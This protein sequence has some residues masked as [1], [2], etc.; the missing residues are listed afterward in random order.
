MNWPGGLPDSKEVDRWISI[1]RRQGSFT[2]QSSAST[3]EFLTKCLAEGKVNYVDVTGMTALHRL[4][5][6]GDG[7]IVQEFLEAGAD[8]E[9]LNADGK[10]ALDV[11]RAVGNSQAEQQISVVVQKAKS[12]RYF[13]TL[14]HLGRVP[15]FAR[16][17][18]AELPELAKAFDWRVYQPGQVVIK[19]GDIGSEFF[20]IADGIAIVEIDGQK[21]NELEKNDY[22]G[23]MALLKGDPRNATITASPGKSLS[24][25]VLS[26][27]SFE[28]L[29][30][31][32]KLTFK[33]RQAVVAVS[34][35]V[36][37]QSQEIPPKTA[38]NLD[39]LLAA[40]KANKAFSEMLSNVSKEEL[41]HIAEKAMP[42]ALP[43]NY[44]IMVEGDVKAD[45]FYIL[46][47]GS[48]KIQI[49]AQ[50]IEAKIFPGGSFGELALMYRAPR[51]ATITT[52]EN[53]V[54]WA[55]SRAQLREVLDKTLRKKIAE[56]KNTLGHVALLQSLSEKEMETVANAV[57]QKEFVEGACIFEQGEEGDAL[58]ILYNGTVSVEKDGAEVA[59][60]TGDSKLGQYQFFGEKALLEDEARAASIKCVSAAVTCLV[61][62]RDSFQKMAAMKEL[63]RPA[64]DEFEY[65]REKLIPL[66]ELGKGAFGLVT[67]QKERETGVKFALK[68]LSKGFVI[69]QHQEASVANEKQIM[70]MTDSPF[71]VRLA[72]TFNTQEHVEFL[73]EAAMGGELYTVYQRNDFY[74][75]EAMARFF[76]A[77]AGAGLSHLHEHNIIY[78][79]LK[80]ENLLLDYRGYGK[81]AD[82]GLAKFVLGPSYTL[83]GTP[84]YF[85]PEICD[86]KGYTKAVDWWGV[87][88]LAFELMTGD[89]P[90][91]ADDPMQLLAEARGGLKQKQFK[92]SIGPWTTFVKAMLSEDASKRL[93]MRNG[94]FQN[95]EAH[96]WFRAG[97]QLDAWNWELFY[98]Q[99]AEPPYKPPKQDENNLSNF[100]PGADDPPQIPYQD[101]GTGWEEDFD[102]HFGPPPKTFLAPEV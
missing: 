59:Q 57:V 19:Q 6:E 83:C 38:E 14:K 75:N 46:E 40:F 93:P 53:S 49:E 77:C 91:Q 79:D 11:A 96:E 97:Q 78:R 89:P 67:L 27:K 2:G 90:F 100:D 1:K 28:D 70:R 86:P 9:I 56:F 36:G 48:C 74:G 26:R 35:Q 13:D 32:Q 68:C 62:H 80:P 18:R 47:Q 16:L 55:L 54:V 66:G 45:F 7:S 31:R 88:I 25:R 87:G 76:C 12:G 69:L 63:K 30:L 82:F 73:M 50:N 3:A 98:Q 65:S 23:E 64:N 43:P 4:A 85:A 94:G 34:A 20:V 81:V 5:S 39:F 99:K 92:G 24:V 33:K 8:P 84:E 15:L 102:D 101:P 22:F 51:K 21:V 42:I 95:F 17:P 52:L 29:R 44:D 71:L 60:L 41:A 10:N 58:Y 61:L 72:A 37:E